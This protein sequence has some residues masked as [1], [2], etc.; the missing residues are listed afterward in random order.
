MAAQEKR[1]SFSEDEVED[2]KEVFMLFD[3]KGDRCIQVGGK[4][5]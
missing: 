4:S 2:F 3:T 1:V 5:V